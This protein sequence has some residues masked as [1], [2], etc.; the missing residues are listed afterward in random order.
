MDFEKA[1]AEVEK[2]FSAVKLALGT[3]PA[4]FFRF[5]YLK[6]PQSIRNYLGTRNVAIFSHDLDSFDFKMRTPEDVVNSVMTKLDQKGK[7]IILM[8][9]FHQVTAKAV[10]TIL[11]ELSAKGF[12]VVHM[13][14]KSAARTI[15]KY[16]VSVANELKEKQ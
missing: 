6:D 15:A 9:D 1:T 4:P 7:G 2:G 3:D 10:P 8:H 12:K 13:V 14:P 11:S 16:D 5:P